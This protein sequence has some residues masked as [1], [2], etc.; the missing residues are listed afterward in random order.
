VS[1]ALYVVRVWF[2]SEHGCVKAPGIYRR[3]S[4][5]PR[6]PGLPLLEM[7]DFTP[8]VNVAILRAHMGEKREMTEAEALCVIAWLRSVQAGA[9]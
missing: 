4:S 6:I 1:A 2:E 8:E 5:A 7:V 3:I 9:A